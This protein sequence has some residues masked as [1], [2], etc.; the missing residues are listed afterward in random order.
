MAVVLL[1]ATSAPAAWAKDDPMAGAQLYATH[2]TACHG[3]NRAGVPPTFPAL[4]DVGK[5]LQPAQ[6]KEK[7]RN[8]GG[9]MPPFS[10]LSQ[11]EVDDLASFLAQ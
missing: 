2:C 6:I 5:R 3:A 8:G 9:L 10:Q 7:I 4:T 11:Q 1:G